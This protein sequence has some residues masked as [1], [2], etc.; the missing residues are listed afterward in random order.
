MPTPKIPARSIVE[1]VNPGSLR[2]LGERTGIGMSNR[3]GDEIRRALPTGWA[4]EIGPVKALVGELL[5]A[6]G[7]AVMVQVMAGLGWEYDPNS[8][9]EGRVA[10]YGDEMEETDA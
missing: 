6:M 3:F 10:A 4:G 9:E 5:T 7:P 1:R 8:E 2:K